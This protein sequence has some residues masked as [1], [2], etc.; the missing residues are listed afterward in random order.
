MTSVTES[1]GTCERLATLTN[2]IGSDH[3]TLLRGKQNGIAHGGEG[4]RVGEV[5][6]LQIFDAHAIVEGGGDSGDAR[7]YVAGR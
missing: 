3:F 1:A 5:Q 4:R 7:G 6:L 2:D